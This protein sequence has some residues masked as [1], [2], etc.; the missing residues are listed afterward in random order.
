MK[1]DGS[2]CRFCPNAPTQVMCIAIPLVD[3]PVRL[4]AQLA[5]TDVIQDCLEQAFCD[6]AVP[7]RTSDANSVNEPRVVIVS[8][9]KCTEGE[10][11]ATVDGRGP[12]FATSCFL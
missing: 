7:V 6:F 3:E 2:R 12:K 8:R 10:R 9:F 4:A 1:S 11:V 5:F